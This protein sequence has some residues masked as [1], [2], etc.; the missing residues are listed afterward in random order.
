VSQA[1][2]ARSQQAF[3]AAVCRVMRESRRRQ[4]L[5]QAEVAQR[6]G[7][8]VSKAALANYETGHRSLRVDV[9]WVIAGALGEDLG[10]LLGAAERGIALRP[11]AGVTGAIT[12]DVNEVMATADPRLGPVKRWFELRTHGGSSSSAMTLDDGAIA[13]LASLMNVSPIECRRILISTIRGVRHTPAP[14]PFSR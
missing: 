14:A 7:G 1:Y 6:T 13:A 3:A 11:A 2:D 10:T 9:L 12:V 8:L 5:T 4:K